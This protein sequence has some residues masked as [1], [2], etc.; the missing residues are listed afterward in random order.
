MTDFEKP[1]RWDLTRR[2]QLG[3][4]ISGE[5][6]PSY[7]AF[8]DQL[9]SCCARVL[10]LAGDSDLIFVG[11]SPES[12]FD[13]LSGLLLDTTWFERLELLHFSM[14]LREESDIRKEHPEAIPSMRSYLHQLGL[15]PER[16]ANGRPV[17]FI[18]LVLSGDTFYRLISFL[19]NWAEDI[20]YDWNGVSRRIRLVGITERTK[21]SP[22]TWRWQQQAE[23]LPLL[24]RGSVKN[25]SIPR[26][27]WQYLGNYQYKVSRSYTPPQWGNLTLS[28]PDHDDRR[29]KA[30]RLA[31]E[32]FEAG[33]AK[34]RRGQFASLLVKEPAMKFSW[35][36]TLVQEIR[37]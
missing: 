29:L 16:I 14:R 2:N 11:R 18:D 28:S 8:S 13:H 20:K 5:K 4:L 37:S 9:L 21:T 7:E 6:S 22:K 31:F 10:A 36:R 35:F 19:R 12:I 32:L 17:A 27:L 23:W 25:A 34:E 24:G 33:R 3:G 26:D 30:L 15:H 1:F